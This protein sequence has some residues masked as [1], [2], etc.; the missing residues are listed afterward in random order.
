MKTIIAVRGAASRGKSTSI[1]LAFELLK[2]AYPNADVQNL[3]TRTTRV[4]IKIIVTIR[5]VQIG[6]ESQGDQTAA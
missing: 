2:D 1:K 3:L 5:G 6:I 4:D